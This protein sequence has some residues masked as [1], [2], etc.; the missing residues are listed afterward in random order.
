M[1]GGR[2][3]AVTGRERSELWRRRGRRGDGCK[4]ERGRGGEKEKKRAKDK[5]EK[6]KER[7]E[8][9]GREG[10][11]VMK[12]VQFTHKRVEGLFDFVR[13]AHVAVRRIFHDEHGRQGEER[14]FFYGWLDEWC[15]T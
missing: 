5:G 14:V 7:D 1:C 3:L 8:G 2:K 9:K 15:N 4:E 6:E 12:N 10:E 13:R 11:G